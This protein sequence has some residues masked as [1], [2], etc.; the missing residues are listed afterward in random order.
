MSFI[1]NKAVVKDPP[2]DFHTTEISQSYVEILFFDC[3]Y[4]I[5]NVFLYERR[6][7]FQDLVI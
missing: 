1:K 5:E 7:N 3:D 6:I 4:R 2:I